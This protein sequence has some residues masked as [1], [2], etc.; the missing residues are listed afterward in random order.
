MSSRYRGGWGVGWGWVGQYMMIDNN[1]K[2]YNILHF[3][4]S[5][6]RSYINVC[7]HAEKKIVVSCG[8]Q[9][10]GIY[11]FLDYAIILVTFTYIFN[12]TDK[13]D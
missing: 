3:D 7:Y 1:L 12:K 13:F 9:I 4:P 6:S 11:K 10:L 2:L 8:I 5:W